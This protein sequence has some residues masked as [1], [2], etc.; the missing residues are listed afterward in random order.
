LCRLGNAGQHAHETQGDAPM[1]ATTA[2]FTPEQVVALAAQLGVSSEVDLEQLRIGMGVELEHGSRDP[3][4]NVTDDDPL[5]TAKIALAHLRELP[6]YYTRLAVLEAAAEG[7]QLRVR[8]VMTRQPITVPDNTPLTVADRLMRERR[9]SGLPVVDQCGALVGVI[10]RTD[11]MAAATGPHSDAW[12]GLPVTAAM[13]APGLTV[14]ADV[15]LADAAARMEEH[16]VHRLVVIEPEGGTPIG[17][18][19][20]TDLA[21]SVAG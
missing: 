15:S 12:Q 3:L 7:R 11:V 21:R 10:S 19:S 17:I 1:I 8:D 6:D 2:S 9:V 13:T 18:L 20:T 14:G 4:T 5:L 16:R